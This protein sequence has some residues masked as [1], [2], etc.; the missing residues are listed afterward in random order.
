MTTTNSTSRRSSSSPTLRHYG[1]AIGCSVRADGDF[2][3]TA[4]PLAEIE[5]RRRAFVDLPW[6]MPDQR[7]GTVVVRVTEPGEHDGAVGDIVIT[8]V[9]DA[10]LG[11]WVGDCAPIVLVGAEREF[12][13]VHGGWRGLA[14][15]VIDAAFSAF[16]ESVAVAVLGP[17]IGACCYE[18]CSD[19]LGR[20]AAG[21]HATSDAIT[22]TTRTGLMALDVTAAVDAACDHHGVELTTLGGCTGCAHDGFSHRVNSDPERHVVAAWRPARAAS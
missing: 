15:G 18:F 3:R 11:C 8:D 22:S 12:A 19:D 9:A 4:R 17:V 7:H 13:I 14:D 16:T 6:T 21:V 10:V 20:V 5:A 1:V 2:H